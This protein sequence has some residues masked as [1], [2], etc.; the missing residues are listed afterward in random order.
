MNVKL[1]QHRVILAQTNECEDEEEAEQ[2]D[3]VKAGPHS[4]TK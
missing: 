3:L 4:T 2:N 1:C